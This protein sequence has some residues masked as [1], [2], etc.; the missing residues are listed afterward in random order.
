MSAPTQ[1]RPG[2]ALSR[3]IDL[4]NEVD[5]YAR[6]GLD[7]LPEDMA[8]TR[9]ELLAIR[10]LVECLTRICQSHPLVAE[11]AEGFAA[12]TAEALDLVEPES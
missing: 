6:E 4:L 5:V 12:D 3:T 10:H 1:W 9:G 8:A 7:L 11:F 2:N